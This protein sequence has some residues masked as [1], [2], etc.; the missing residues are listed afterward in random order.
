MQWM[1]LGGRLTP[2]PQTGHALQQSLVA[3]AAW[4]F[5]SIHMEGGIFILKKIGGWSIDWLIEIE[6]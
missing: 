3:V 2:E 5:K 6:R 4:T 1:D